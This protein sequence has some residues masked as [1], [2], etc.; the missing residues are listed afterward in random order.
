MLT[1][2]QWYQKLKSWVPTWYFES[3]QYNVAVF[4]AIAKLLSRSQDVADQ[5][6]IETFL[7]QA[8]GEFVDAHGDE[9][10]VKRLPGE[11]DALYAPRIQK[12]INQSD[13][14]DI[15][16]IVDALLIVGK[17]TIIEHAIEGPF[18]NRG[19][20]LNRKFIF[21]DRRYYNYFTVL[22]DKQIPLSNSF[23]NRD[24]YANRKNYLGSLGPLS[25]DL[26]LAIIN[27]SIN[28]ARAA[29]V[30]YRLIEQ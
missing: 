6:F 27:A 26:L 13:R 2:E 7:L 23:L 30:M 11:P 3:E 28:R 18:C 14:P 19:A 8:H 9:R 20:Y 5:H 4:N 21:T 15:Q 1:K 24:A 25:I 17:A 22:I 29:G 10:N 16:A 12:I